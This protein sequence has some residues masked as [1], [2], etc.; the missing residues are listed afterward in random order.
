MTTRAPWT[1]QWPHVTSEGREQFW[2]ARAQHTR[3]SGQDWVG[4]RSLEAR[5]RDLDV[6]E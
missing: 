5:A 1:E 3:Q 4:R 6:R 2:G